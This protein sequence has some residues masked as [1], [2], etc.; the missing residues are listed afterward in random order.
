MSRLDPK[1][2]YHMLFW[3]EAKEQLATMEHDILLAEAGN[4]NEETINRIFRM[5]HS[6]KGSAATLG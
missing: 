6:I 5:A 4:S 1:D 2:T 3:E